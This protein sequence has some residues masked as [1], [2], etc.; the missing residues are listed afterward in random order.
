[1]TNFIATIGDSISITTDIVWDF[2]QVWV[3]YWM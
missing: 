1:M 3:R 2:L